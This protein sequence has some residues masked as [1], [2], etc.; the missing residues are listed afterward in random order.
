[1]A[2]RRTKSI[3][4]K[5]TDAEYEQ[6]ASAAAPLT[7]SEWARNV[8]LHATQPDPIVTALLAEVLASSEGKSCTD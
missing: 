7:I 3:S 4:T 1:M 2:T 5:V 8:L 6:A